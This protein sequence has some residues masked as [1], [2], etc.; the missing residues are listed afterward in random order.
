[1]SGQGATVTG[2]PASPPISRQAPSMQSVQPPP[3][4]PDAAS[5]SDGTATPGT[6]SHQPPTSR[7]PSPGSIPAP[8]PR[9]RARSSVRRSAPTRQ[10]SRHSTRSTEWVQARVTVGSASITSAAPMARQVTRR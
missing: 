4:A 9:T 3:V 8:E 7:A 10:S 2:A 1:M 6:H 5:A